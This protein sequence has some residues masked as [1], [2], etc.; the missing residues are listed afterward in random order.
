ML[1]DFKKYFKWL[2]TGDC[3]YLFLAVLLFLPFLFLIQYDPKLASLWLIFTG[4]IDI[5]FAIWLYE[6]KNKIIK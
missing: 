5:T 3:K 4:F 2:T 6:E 1:K